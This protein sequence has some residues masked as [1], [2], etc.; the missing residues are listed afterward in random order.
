MALSLHPHGA[1]AE[2]QRKAKAVV[3]SRQDFRAVRGMQQH[4]LPPLEPGLGAQGQERR[5]DA[6][7]ASD[8]ARRRGS[9]AEK[10]AGDAFQGVAKR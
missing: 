2:I 5:E 3:Q 7:V 6:G 4:R 8:V 1:F 10:D 9:A